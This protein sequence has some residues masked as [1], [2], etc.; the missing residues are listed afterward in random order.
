MELDTTCN[1]TRMA[2][3]EAPKID[4]QLDCNLRNHLISE[5]LLISFF[6]FFSFS[7]W[8]VCACRRYYRGDNN[9]H[10]YGPICAQRLYKY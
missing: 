6:V 9:D 2:D 8:E 7:V 10:S 5:F 3:V 4:E 1:Y